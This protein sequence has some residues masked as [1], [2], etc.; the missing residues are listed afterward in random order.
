MHETRKAPPAPAADADQDNDSAASVAGGA[1]AS[2]NAAGADASDDSDDSSGSSPSSSQQNDS[3][4]YSTPDQSTQIQQSGPPSVV[5]PA[6]PGAGDDTSGG[7]DTPA[8]GSDDSSDSDS[9]ESSG[10]GSGASGGDDSDSDDSSDQN[11]APGA[12]PADQAGNPPGKLPQV[13]MSPGLKDEYDHAN[14]M[15][16]Q[17]LY[18][19]PGNKLAAAIVQGLMPQGPAKIKNAAVVSLHVL[20]QIHKKLN[21]PPQIILIFTKD[22]VSHVLDLGEQVKKIQYS[23]QEMTAILGTAYE[24]AMRIFGVNKG[25][26]KQA[27]RHLGRNVL[28]HHQQ[29]YQKAHAFAKS[30]I[31]KNNAGWHNDDLANAPAQMGGQ[32]GA[33][34]GTAVGPP[35]TPGPQTGAP[36]GAQMTPTAGAP[37][38]PPMPQGGPLAQAAAASQAA[39]GGG[40]QQ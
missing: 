4:T 10:S 7:A 26:V 27:A 36:P 33:Q 31:D 12:S 25:Q 20:T 40:Q 2:Q 14:Q 3:E 6:A 29:A 21:L 30:A 24:G 32:P 1:G 35:Q 28:Q 19:T 37:P 18:G 8:S 38:Q 39:Q 11:A 13:P 15:L 22:V 9:D 34:G 16:M 17:L 23:D 5:N